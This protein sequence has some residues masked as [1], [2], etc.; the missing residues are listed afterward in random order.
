MKVQ[1]AVSENMF[2]STNAN[3]YVL[4]QVYVW[5]VC[6]YLRV[7]HVCVCGFVVYIF[8]QMFWDVFECVWASILF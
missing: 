4:V 5:G 1:E 7:V 3:D 2:Y 6:V 8:I